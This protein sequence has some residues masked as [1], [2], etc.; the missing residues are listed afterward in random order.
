MD[1]VAKRIAMQRLFYLEA[2]QCTYQYKWN[3]FLIEI[4]DKYQLTPP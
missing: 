4:V 2:T 1:N 3:I